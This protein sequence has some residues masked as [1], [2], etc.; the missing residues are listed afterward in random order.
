MEQQEEIFQVT[1]QINQGLEPMT[2][3]VIAKKNDT[4]GPDHHPA[5]KITR[6]KA[7]ETL[8][9]LTLDSDHCWE[10]IKRNYGTGAG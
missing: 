5:F 9:V 7:D 10:L 4:L 8:A 6:D 1:V 2:L 3:T